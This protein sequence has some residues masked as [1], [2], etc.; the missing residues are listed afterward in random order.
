MAMLVVDGHAI[1]RDPSAL[2]WGLQ[3]I[4]AADAGRTQD[5]GNSMVKNRVSQ[6][7]KLS[8]T[9]NLPHQAAAAEIL[10]AFNP[11]YF[12]VQYFDPMD[13]QV[14]TRTFYAGDRSAVFRSYEVPVVGGTTF[15]TVSFDIIEV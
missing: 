8:I 1:S 6:K 11:E 7:R 12:S 10:S 9:W 5:S 3:D 13:G 14:E 2:T 15:Q 4:S